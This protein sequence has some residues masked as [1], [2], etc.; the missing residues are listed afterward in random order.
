MN[1]EISFRMYLSHAVSVS[2]AF[3]KESRAVFEFSSMFD[4]F[5]ISFHTVIKWLY[6]RPSGIQFIVSVYVTVSFT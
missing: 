2:I 6:I 3:G 4:G 1:P 5:V